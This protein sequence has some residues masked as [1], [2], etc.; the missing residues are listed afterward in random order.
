MKRFFYLFSLIFSFL[1]I[2]C[3]E[4]IILDFDKTVPRLVIE[5]NIFVEEEIARIKLSTTTDFYSNV[6]PKVDGAQ[7]QLINPET[8]E[9]YMFANIGEGN[10]IASNITFE[11]EGN[12]ELTVVYNNETYRAAS[13]LLPSPEV[14]DVDQKND[15]GFSGESYEINF[16][17]QDNPNE[18][19]YYLVQVVSPVDNAF[20]VINDQFSN[21]NIMS[22]L[23]FYDKEDIK[24]GDQ[25]T[26]Y[27][28]SIN[29]QY[30]NYL[31]KLFSISGESGNP[32]ASPVGTIKGNIVNQ[33]NEEN[34]ALGYFHIAK[35]N[36]YNYIV[37]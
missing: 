6:F 11:E 2:S 33:T 23:Y 25:L 3:E 13:T 26:H 29:K 22:D 24:P 27:I 4:D 18:E 37:K 31:S 5:G 1:F 16:N 35:R 8:N 7:V 12:Y 28:T 17:F 20:G 21:G 10:Y 15:G 34:F 14:I 19:N 9:I 30:Y 32:F 36:Q